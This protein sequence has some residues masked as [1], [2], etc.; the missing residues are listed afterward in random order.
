MW[1]GI[2]SGQRTRIMPTP[3]PIAAMST[4]MAMLIRFLALDWWG[5]GSLMAP[6]TSGH[7]FTALS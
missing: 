6:Q 1:A 4:A 2:W 3:W 7:G 5:M